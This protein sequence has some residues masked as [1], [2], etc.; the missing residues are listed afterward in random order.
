MSNIV[1]RP[2]RKSVRLELGLQGVMLSNGDLFLTGENACRSKARK[3]IS[4][5]QAQDPKVNSVEVP[6][7]IRNSKA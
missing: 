7:L 2:L 6:T 5:S 4:H 3:V 1:E